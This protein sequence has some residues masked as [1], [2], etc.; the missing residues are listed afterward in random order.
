MTVRNKDSVW[1]KME[2]GAESAEKCYTLLLMGGGE[3]RGWGGG[4]FLL[5]T[6]CIMEGVIECQVDT[7]IHSNNRTKKQI[8][9]LFFWFPYRVVSTGLNRRWTGGRRGEREG[10]EGECVLVALLLAG[11][12]GRTSC[13]AA[14][15]P[16][17]EKVQY[18]YDVDC[19][20]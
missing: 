16:C 2:H 14:T 20:L 3:G 10:R 9:G 1:E 8:V 12:S 5:S 11:S 6:R 19:R 7:G 13:K 4:F 17:G 15:P 18:S